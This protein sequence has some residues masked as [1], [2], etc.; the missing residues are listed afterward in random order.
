MFRV[1]PGQQ[2]SMQAAGTLAGRPVL[3][4]CIIRFGADGSARNGP[5]PLFM[6]VD[7]PVVKL[8]IEGARAEFEGRVGEA[9]VFYERAWDAAT[10]DYEA[11]I[12]AHYVARFQDNPESRLRWNREALER[13]YAAGGE[14]VEEF[15]P[16]LYLNLGSSYEALGDPTEAQRYYDLAAGLGFVHQMES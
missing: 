6:D 9:R 10:D 1:I 15:Y 14:R 4:C 16:S 13:A 11:C 3:V 8:C 2:T 7:N 5:A 12:A